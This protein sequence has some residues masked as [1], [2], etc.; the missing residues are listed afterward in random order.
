MARASPAACRAARPGSGSPVARDLDRDGGGVVAAAAAG[1]SPTCLA[2]RAGRPRCRE[3]AGALEEELE[4]VEVGG[5]RRRV[6]RL[7]ATASPSERPAARRLEDHV[8]GEHGGE[9]WSDR[10][11]D[12]VGGELAVGVPGG[13]AGAGVGAAGEVLVA[14][15]DR[16]V[17]RRP[18]AP[19]GESARPRC[20]TSGQPGRQRRQIRAGTGHCRS[21]HEGQQERGRE[22]ELARLLIQSA[23]TTSQR[24]EARVRA[25]PAGLARVKAVSPLRK[26]PGGAIPSLSTNGSLSI[27]AHLVRV[28]GRRR[29]PLRLDRRTGQA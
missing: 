11:L 28:R 14:E 10:L 27:L 21:G 18:A 23:A 12:V 25:S 5:H 1:C 8:V 24:E 17:A 20:S 15:A 13:P 3:G 7:V 4:V 26:N 2:R 29:L 19:P 16:G 22:R 9:P 6:R